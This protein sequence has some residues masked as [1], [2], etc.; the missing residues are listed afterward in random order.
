MQSETLK[1]THIMD[2]I[3][4]IMKNDGLDETEAKMRLNL[5]YIKLNEAE[6]KT[7]HDEF[8]EWLMTEKKMNYK[9]ILNTTDHR[10][11]DLYLFEFRP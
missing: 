7:Y 4:H 5:L 6:I 2:I 10:L 1:N 9:T 11:H 8:I 3:E